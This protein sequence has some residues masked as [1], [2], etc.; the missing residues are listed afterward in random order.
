M[1]KIFVLGHDPNLLETIREYLGESGHQVDHKSFIDECIDA[2]KSKEHRPDLILV[3]DLI[4]GM[5]SWD[6]CHN[7]KSRNL[8]RYIPV[9]PIIDYDNCLREV[10]KNCDLECDG[11]ITRPLRREKFMAK[12][13][14]VLY[15][16]KLERTCEILHH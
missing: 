4:I 7:I 8:S 16:R 12:I 5:N 1:S 6:V 11:S 15:H 10:Y 9:I 14:N 3:S 2:C 13:N